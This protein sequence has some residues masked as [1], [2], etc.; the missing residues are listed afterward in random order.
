MPPAQ[1]GYKRNDDFNGAS[2]E[3]VG[4][5]QVTQKDRQ[6]W[7]AASAYLRPAVERNRNNV[8]VISNAT[9]RAHHP[10]QGPRHGR[11]LQAERR[12]R[13]GRAL[14]PRDHPGGRRRQLAA[15]PDAVGHRPGRPSEVGRHPPAARPA[16]RRRQSA[17]PS[18]CRPAAVLQDARHLRHG[19]QAGVALPVLEAQEGPRHLADR[20]IGRLHPHAARAS[21]RPTSSSTSCRSWWSITAARR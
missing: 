19:Q 14:Q 4:Y 15:A 1:A 3:G 12:Q 2:Q 9:G 17:G 11:A 7:S 10:R 16:G 8:H 18:R 21:A 6:R 13:R 5:Y 20:R